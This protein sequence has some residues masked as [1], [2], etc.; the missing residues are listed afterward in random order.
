MFS[1]DVCNRW[2]STFKLLNQSIH[3]KTLLCSFAAQHVP[4]NHLL[5]TAWNICEKF[6]E[7]LKHF[8]DATHTFSY[9]YRPTSHEFL[10]QGL[11]VAGVF[12]EGE[13]IEEIKYTI[14]QMK[15]K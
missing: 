13:K 1:K 14:L 9:V 12:M 15:L 8:Y 11:N 4:N 10:D 3:Y 5:P 6:M 2:N 7:V